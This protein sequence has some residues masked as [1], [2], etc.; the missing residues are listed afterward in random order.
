MHCVPWGS[1]PF[2]SFSPGAPPVH[3]GSVWTDVLFLRPPSSRL[4]A[5]L[6]F[7]LFS[8]FC[9]SRLS[10]L[11]VFLLF[12]SFC[13]SRNGMALGILLSCFVTY[14][15]C[16]SVIGGVECAGLDGDVKGR[17]EGN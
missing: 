11:L 15:R 6:V 1:A 5:L 7:L 16:Q 8:S 12:S 14:F 4:S 17:E 10:A 9:S 3:A 13:S 2:S